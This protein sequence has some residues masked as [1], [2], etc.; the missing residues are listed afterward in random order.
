MDCSGVNV[1]SGGHTG[2]D[3]SRNSNCRRTE[4]A[5]R[6]ICW[7]HTWR[8]RSLAG[9]LAGS[10]AADRILRRRA[11]EKSPRISPFQRTGPPHNLFKD[12]PSNSGADCVRVK[13]ATQLWFCSVRIMRDI[14]YLGAVRAALTE[15]RLSHTVSLNNC[16]FAAIAR[17]W[18]TQSP[19][20]LSL[21]LSL[22]TTAIDIENQFYYTSKLLCPAKCVHIC[23]HTSAAVTSDSTGI[24][25]ACSKHIYKAQWTIDSDVVVNSFHPFL[26]WRTAVIIVVRNVNTYFT[27]A[28]YFILRHCADDFSGGIFLTYSVPANWCNVYT[29]EKPRAVWTERIMQPNSSWFD[30]VVEQIN[31]KSNRWFWGTNS[32]H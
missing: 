21:S 30:S 15:S 32:H 5:G 19:F 2:R 25:I 12:R 9:W 28:F 4:S 22:M 16:S 23:V 10:A 11:T 6:R 31:S 20:S 14:D 26:F 17:R 24:T 27:A 3:S 18:I 7:W 1:T 13:D 29:A 8:R